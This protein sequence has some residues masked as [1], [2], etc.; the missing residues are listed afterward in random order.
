MADRNP[1]TPAL[2]VK[3]TLLY[4]SMLTVMAAAVIAMAQMAIEKEFADVPNAPLLTRMMLTLPA[5]MIGIIAPLAGYIIDTFGRKRLLV[6][7]LVLYVIGG[8]SGFWLRYLG[9][10]TMPMLLAGR[11]LLGLGVAGN[12]TTAT[13][14]VGDF[15]RG[16]ARSKFYGIQ[17]GFMA[18]GGLVFI[19]GGGALADI[20]WR[21]P[22]LVYAAALIAIPMVLFLVPE[23]PR[24]STTIQTESK[25]TTDSSAPL[26]LGKAVLICATAFIGMM[27]FYNAPVQLPHYID[28]ILDVSNFQGAVTIGVGTLTGALVSMN[29]GYF[30][31]R[32]SHVGIY[33]LC[34]FL[35]G[36][37][38]GAVWLSTAYWHIIVSMLIVGCGMGLLMP[39][40]NLWMVSIAPEER[41]GRL[42]SALTSTTFLGQFLSAI[43]MQSLIAEGGL[44]FVF[45]VS[46][47]GLLGLG[48]GYGIP[49]MVRRLRT[50]LVFE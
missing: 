40:S 20:S 46:A 47:I 24:R 41:R 19:S 23:P 13:T 18:L 50:G 28:K 29:Y 2:G 12:M 14:L 22:F 31:A 4:A 30:K 39:N 15:F 3:I 25:E 17:A 5:L 11:V 21:M 27:L 37:G 10:E 26:P 32:L 48:L 8:T 34:F 49:A 6:F 36:I 9:L 1:T 38:F 7:S 42:V 45:E 16:R 43:V 35:M 44:A 33:G